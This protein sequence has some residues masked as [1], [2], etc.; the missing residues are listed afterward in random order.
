[1]TNFDTNLPPGWEDP[2]ARLRMKWGE[3]PSGRSRQSSAQLLAAD[4]LALVEHWNAS[5]A[6]DTKGIGFGVRGWYHETY[7]SLMPGK[8]VLDIGCGLGLSTLCFAEMGARLTFTDIIPDNVELVR[9]LCAAKGVQAEFLWIGSFDDYDKLARDY[10]IVT[11]IGSLHNTPLAVTKAEINRIKTHLKVG[12]RWLHFAYPKVRWE[13]EGKLSFVEWG[14]RTDGRGTPW[15]EYHD[16]EKVE[17][18]FAPSEIQIL[19][20]CEWH[21]CDFNWFDIELIRH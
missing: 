8:K 4:P 3:V 11:S 6:H 17:W 9:R 2:L 12:G 7:R 18:L 10:D 5:R 19:F 21:N 13:R 1:M 20:D 14:Q 15:V 16:R